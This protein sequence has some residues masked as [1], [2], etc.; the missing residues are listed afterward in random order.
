MVNLTFNSCLDRDWQDSNPGGEEIGGL[1]WI[2][3]LV[4]NTKDSRDPSYGHTSVK[5]RTLW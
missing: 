2:D 4:N 1:A 3:L 5:P